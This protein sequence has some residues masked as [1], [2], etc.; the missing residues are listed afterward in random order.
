MIEIDNDN[1][2]LMTVTTLYFFN[3]P[4]T[5][6]LISSLLKISTLQLQLTRILTS[7]S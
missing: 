1:M 7:S 4:S 6:K 3:R 5:L 2:T